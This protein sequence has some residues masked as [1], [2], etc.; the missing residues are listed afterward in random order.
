[1]EK[2]ELCRWLDNQLKAS[3]NDLMHKQYSLV[4]KETIKHKQSYHPGV[5]T[6]GSPPAIS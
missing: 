5:A 2:C 6:T 3:A 4:L 1:M